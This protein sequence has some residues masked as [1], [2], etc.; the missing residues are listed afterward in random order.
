MISTDTFQRPHFHANRASARP[1][2]CQQAQRALIVFQQFQGRRGVRIQAHEIGHCPEGVGEL[3]QELSA[4]GFRASQRALL[5][6]ERTH[7]MFSN[8]AIARHKATLQNLIDQVINAG[9]IALVG[10]SIAAALAIGVPMSAGGGTQAAM[11]TSEWRSL[12]DQRVF[13]ASRHEPRMQRLFST[14]NAPVGQGWG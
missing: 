9:L 14:V 4:H 1:R 11:P 2:C 8:A 12:F 13:R 10:C 5:F 3:D 7:T 6:N